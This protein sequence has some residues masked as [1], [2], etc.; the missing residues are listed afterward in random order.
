MENYWLYIEPYVYIDILENQAILYNTLNKKKFI[1]NDKTTIFLLKELTAEQNLRVTII[2]QQQ[3]QLPV[4]K[5]L[6]DSYSGDILNTNDSKQKPV[7]FVPELRIKD[8]NSTGKYQHIYELS[9]YLTG[10]CRLNCSHCQNYYKQFLYCKTCFTKELSINTIQQL[11]SQINYEYI[12]QINLL[13]GNIF[14]YSQIITL[15]SFLS[16]FKFIKNLF[17]NLE[18]IKNLHEFDIFLKYKK[19]LKVTLL[20]N[21]LTNTSIKKLKK[22]TEYLISIELNYEL[23]FVVENEKEYHLIKKIQLKQNDKII[24]YC[25]VENNMYFFKHNVFL[26][27][28]DILSSNYSVLDILKNKVINKNFYGK[29]IVD[30]DGAIYISFNENKIGLISADITSIISQLSDQPLYKKTRMQVYPCS[31]CLYR[32]LCPPLSNYELFTK[33]NDLCL[34]KHKTS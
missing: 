12:S 6:R 22:V 24:P 32:F 27:E 21:N 15:L 14:S 25:N 28:Q 1:V 33:K 20:I 18:H 16:N 11:L 17:F 13:G 19:N 10:E 30:T 26:R 31:N 3:K 34:I 2:S 29:L 8:N 9:L 7:Q 5:W 4:I 23:L